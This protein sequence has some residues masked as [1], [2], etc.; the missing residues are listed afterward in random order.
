MKSYVAEEFDD[1]FLIL[2]EGDK[3]PFR[4]AKNALNEEAKADIRKNIPEGMAQGGRLKKGDPDTYITKEGKETERGLWANVYL[5]KKRE[6][7]LADGGEIKPKTVSKQPTK[8]EML[9]TLKGMFKDAGTAEAKRTGKGVSYQREPNVTSAIAVG[10]PSDKKELPG[11]AVNSN[12]YRKLL[13]GQNE[14]EKQETIDFLTDQHYKGNDVFIDNDVIPADPQA[15]KL[16]LQEIKNKANTEED[17]FV[18]EMPPEELAGGGEVMDQ[19][20]ASGFLKEIYPDEERPQLFLFA[21]GGYA[22]SRSSER[23]GKTHK[24]TGPGGKVMFFGDPD[25]K[26]RPQNEGARKSFYARH[27]KSLAKNPFF[28]AYARAT[29]ADGGIIPGYQEGGLAEAG[30]FAEGDP[31]QFIDIGGGALPPLA[32]PEAPEAPEAPEVEMAAEEAPIEEEPVEEPALPR[33]AVPPV[34]EVLNPLDPTPEEIENPQYQ[35]FLKRFTD[36]ELPAPGRLAATAL[37][38]AKPTEAEIK[39]ATVAPVET[40]PLVEEEPVETLAGVTKPVDPNKIDLALLSRDTAIAE[41]DTLLKAADREPDE[42]QKSQLL[43]LAAGTLKNARLQQAVLTG[44]QAGADFDKFVADEIQNKNTIAELKRQELIVKTAYDTKEAA[45]RF[46]ADEERAKRMAK[47]QDDIDKVLV[48]LKDKRIDP[49]RLMNN[50]STLR[51]GIATAFGVLGKALG[52]KGSVQDYIDTQIK[53]DIDAQV[54]DLT[55][56]TGLLK[57]YIDAGNSF[58]NSYKLT[59]AALRDVAAAE[60]N[61]LIGPIRQ[62]ALAVNA[63]M[64]AARLKSDAIKKR[65][66]VIKAQIDAE[67]LP[68]KLLLQ[69]DKLDNSEE[70]ALARER[71][72]VSREAEKGRERRSLRTTAVATRKAAE[73]ERR[74]DISEAEKLAGAEEKAEEKVGGTPVQQTFGAGFPV[75][76]SDVKGLTKEQQ[77]LQVN[78]PGK[79]GFVAAVKSGDD[80]KKL[81]GA[82][83]TLRNVKAGIK[84]LSELAKRNP[85][86][87]VVVG[88]VVVGS[89]KQAADYA[90]AKSFQEGLLSN[91]TELLQ[92]GVINPGDAARLN[93]FIPQVTNFER[94]APK[95]ERFNSFEKSV[96]DS[97]NSAAQTFFRKNPDEMFDTAG[98][99]VPFKA[100]KG[101]PKMRPQPPRGSAAAPAG[102]KKLPPGASAPVIIRP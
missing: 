11:S 80:A 19:E 52:S 93:S 8:K 17:V 14:T 27:A 39:V 60:L 32:V 12:A 37:R 68:E 35:E 69:L 90:A 51:F 91:L 96:T 99:P 98:K 85:N 55:K 88:G 6:G 9:K 47:Y 81:K 23:K 41:Y 100:E 54:S 73:T 95:M 70:L 102:A 36:L 67:L 58:T 30:N 43:A 29:W 62:D 18:K 24:V 2:Y 28:R 16:R 79:P 86:G 72:E 63:R 92:T 65:N 83:R 1:Y 94:T 87:F 84:Q 42:Q 101:E 10:K 20:A 46:K 66:E 74:T 5:K 4:V 75:K 53:R 15:K 48:D 50:T 82:E 89:D 78:V 21:D 77:D 13:E 34:Q 57:Q 64:E 26:N 71:I 31:R 61:D 3:K 22:V 44:R 76:A 33:Q 59:E 25:L 56:R 97:Y 40:K 38:A 7:K 49:D 45:R